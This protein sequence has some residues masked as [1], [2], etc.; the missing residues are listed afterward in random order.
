MD[1]EYKNQELKAQTAIYTVF[2]Q[3]V[4]EFN[5][6]SKGFYGKIELIFEDGRITAIQKSQTIKPD[7]NLR[8][9]AASLCQAKAHR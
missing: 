8:I 2:A 6:V 9:S 1:M 4:E 3:K 5:L 7:E